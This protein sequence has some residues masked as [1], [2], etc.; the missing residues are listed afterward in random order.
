MVLYLGGAD[1]GVSVGHNNK[2]YPVEAA[3]PRHR[4]S[5]LPAEGILN[6]RFNR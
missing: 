1:A 6:C 5:V 3:L 2:A 4:V